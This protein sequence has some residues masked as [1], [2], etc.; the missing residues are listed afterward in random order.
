MKGL[1]G[2]T[3]ASSGSTRKATEARFTLKLRLKATSHSV[4]SGR[5]WGQPLSSTQPLD[6]QRRVSDY[7]CSDRMAAIWRPGVDRPLIGPAFR[8]TAAVSHGALV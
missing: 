1:A 5:Y 7:C 4:S 2:E 3:T 6:S 8:H